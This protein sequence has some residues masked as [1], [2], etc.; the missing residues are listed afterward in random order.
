MIRAI[1]S[2]I[3]LKNIS[4]LTNCVLYIRMEAKDFIRN[5]K[6]LLKIVL[7]IA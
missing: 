5:T 3:L 1:C 6:K 2:C 7:R 4:S